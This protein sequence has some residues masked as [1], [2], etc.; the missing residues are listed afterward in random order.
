M[1]ET[2]HGEL[3]RLGEQLACM[4]RRAAE[5]IRLAGRAFLDA[6][7]ELAQR[8]LDADAELDRERDRC[9]E[10]AHALLALQA[11]VARDLRAVLTAVYCAGKIERMGDL[12]AHV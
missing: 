2:F 10:H 4:C 1:R 5:S 9:E 12:A 11:P 7:V 8:G 3:A 6:D